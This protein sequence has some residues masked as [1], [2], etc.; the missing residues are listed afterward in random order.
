MRTRD[1]ETGY[2]CRN[3]LGED[4]GSEVRCRRCGG[5]G[6][7]HGGDNFNRETILCLR[8]ADDWF[9][10]ARPLFNKHGW[11]DARSSPKKWMAAFNEFLQTKP[12][13][14]DIQVHNHRIESKDRRFFGMFPHLKKLVEESDSKQRS[15]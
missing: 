4:Y 10:A 11:R 9:E 13:E 15:R 6:M 2:I 3:F 14:I 12:K 1:P 5:R 7:W 8:C